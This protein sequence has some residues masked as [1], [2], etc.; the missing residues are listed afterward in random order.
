MALVAFGGPFVDLSD[1]LTTRGVLA[2]AAQHIRLDQL[3]ASLRDVVAKGACA[4]LERHRGRIRGVGIREGEELEE[5]ELTFEALETPP[6][7][8][9]NRECP[10]GL[11]RAGDDSK[12][13]CSAAWLSSHVHDDMTCPAKPP[14]DW[15]SVTTTWSGPTS[16]SVA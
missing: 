15:W 11:R 13:W 1:Q 9:R 3:R 7:R 16:P 14:A 10:V 5:V 12:L 6:D 8:R 4:L 2:L